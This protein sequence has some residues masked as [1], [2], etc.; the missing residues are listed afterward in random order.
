VPVR[1]HIRVSGVVQGVGMRPFVY[2]LAA[3]HGVSGWVLNDALGVEIEAEGRAEAVDAFVAAISEQAPPLARISA[4]EVSHIEPI[5]GESFEIR[6]SGAGPSP[7]TLIS[8][9]VS[10]CDDCLREMADPQ[11]RR[12]R[13]PFINCTN[14]GPRY[15][16]IRELPYDRGG[17]TMD[18]FEMCRECRAEYEDPADRRFHAQPVACPACGPHVWLADAAGTEL[19]SDDPVA[20]ASEILAAGRI[21]AVKGL[22]GFHLAVDATNEDAV[23]RL[24][25]RKA[26]EKKPLAVMSPD[27]E[28][29][30][31][32]CELSRAEE[33]LLLSPERPIV[34][35]RKKPGTPLAESVAPR[36][37]HFGVMLPYT[38]LHVLLVEHGF[39]ALVMTS[40]NVTDEPVCY[41][42]AD[43]LARLSEI[44]D[45]YLLHDRPIHIRTDDSVARVISDEARLM[46]RARGYVPRPVVLGSESREAILAVGPELKNTICLLR[47]REAF[48]SHH[49]GD[50]KNVAAYEGMKQAV[51]HLQG[52]LE[53]EPARVACDMHPQYLST[54]WARE[55][56]L[57]VTA[58]QHH[59]AHIASCMAENGAAGPVIGVSLDGTG[60]G[61]DG[62]VWGGE[63]LVAEFSRFRRAA[64]LEY[65]AMPGG[66]KAAQEPWRMALSH[67]YAVHGSA[68]LDMDLPLLERVGR[69]RA[70]TV[71]TMIERGV[72]SPPTSSMGRLFDAAS[73]L[74]GLRDTISYEG[75]AAIE[76]EGVAALGEN[77][78]Y[79]CSLRQEGDALVIAAE[80]IIGALVDDLSAGTGPEVAAARFHNAVLDMVADVVARLREGTGLDEVALAGGVWQNARLLAGAL[81]RL[82]ATGMAVHA[83]RLVPPN[84]GGVSLGQ[85]AIAAAG[86]GASDA[87]A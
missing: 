34:L 54:L 55:S 11:D 58:V 12:Y 38:P 5:G 59:H 36:N 80:E 17:T 62:A 27:V 57:P 77:G 47:G 31:R 87:P 26:R 29:V 73:S 21:V 85:A 76:L 50:L 3:R 68:L 75:Q 81:E 40:G 25:S 9:D 49:I 28:S 33:K 42:N 48:L 86:G 51:S 43:A 70:Q 20:R 45:A 22:G 35:L 56:G 16:I 60:Y 30:R 83:H 41:E 53:I 74:C 7:A 18:R 8:P 71:V 15:T 61:T 24:R 82:G 6:P 19:A 13:Y 63:F 32:F 72:N 64:R 4:V 69:D 39:P 67:L 66:D 84:D 52:V 44:A 14:C 1:V 2:S 79:P 23:R 10:V 78:S 37:Q 46:R 65:V